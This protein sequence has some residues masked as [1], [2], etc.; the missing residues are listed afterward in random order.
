[1]KK[2]KRFLIAKMDE[3]KANGLG[4]SVWAEKKDLNG[5]T[6]VFLYIGKKV[7]AGYRIEPGLRK[8]VVPELNFQEVAHPK[9]LS[10][11]AVEIIREIE[12]YAS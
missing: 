7:I 10:I 3:C 8:I 5:A 6:A 1:M 4:G 2:F 9:C 12:S 11:D